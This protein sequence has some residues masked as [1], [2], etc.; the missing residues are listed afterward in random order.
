[1]VED[2]SRDIL[3]PQINFELTQTYD[4]VLLDCNRN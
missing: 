4:I 2:R 1:M 3:N